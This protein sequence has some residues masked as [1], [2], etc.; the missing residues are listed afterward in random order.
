MSKC[1]HDVRFHLMG[2]T[3][4]C[5]ACHTEHLAERLTTAEALLREACE[6][7]YIDDFGDECVHITSRQWLER[8]K[9]AV[10]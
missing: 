7:T 4:G 10:R 9:E 5:C 1:N 2:A 3:N 6:S 8:A